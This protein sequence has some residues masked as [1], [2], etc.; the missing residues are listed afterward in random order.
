MD[1]DDLFDDDLLP[2]PTPGRSAAPVRTARVAP[3]PV[4]HVA[5][6]DVLADPGTA[7]APRPGSG[8]GPA[9]DSRGCVSG[10]ARAGSARWP[11]CS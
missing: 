5:G 1:H 7:R 8:R 10:S 3:Q 2:D 4:E 6:V 11:C 9:V